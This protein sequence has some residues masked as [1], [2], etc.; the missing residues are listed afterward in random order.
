MEGEL[1][2]KRWTDATPFPAKMVIN[3]GLLRLKMEVM[4]VVDS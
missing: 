1:E 2:G 4:G 3:R